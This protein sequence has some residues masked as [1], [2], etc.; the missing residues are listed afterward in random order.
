MFLGLRK[1]PN[2]R[3]EMKAILR[4]IFGHTNHWNTENIMQRI[5]YDY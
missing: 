2:R 5:G 3:Y 4:K 1:S